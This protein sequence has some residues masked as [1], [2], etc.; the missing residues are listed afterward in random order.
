MKPLICVPMGDP[1]GIGPE[2]VI[3]SVSHAR[4]NDKSRIL[5]TGNLE[6]LERAAGVCE[7]SV[8]INTIEAISDLVDQPNVLNLFPVVCPPQSS[9]VFG[10]VSDIAGITAY[11][12]IEAAVR[13]AL[14]GVVDAIATTPIN[15]KSLRAA[16][17]E[18]I[19]HTEIL[20][21]LTNCPD[22]LTLFQVHGL[23][24]FFLSR[25]LS[26]RQACDFI[27]SQRIY[28]CAVRAV[29]ALRQL[30]VSEPRLAIAA[31]N[32]HAGEDGLF[33]DEE[34]YEIHPAV[35]QL[36][37]D[38]FSVAG[39]LPADS[40]FHQALLGQYDAVVSL[41]HDQGHIATKMID[42][43]KTISITCGLPFLRTSVDH[44]T[45]FDIA[46]KGFANPVS[47]IE[48]IQLAAKYAVPVKTLL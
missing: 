14:D 32:P 38:G 48:A 43:E 9:V 15:K 30:G 31:L 29:S 45:A 41:Y 16:G 10:Q 20:A 2:L 39:P 34:I 1:A 26:L 19:G 18:H 21:E 3:R 37:K 44:G 25:H 28:D 24:V 8:T 36:R 47:M 12:C 6:A 27:T 23:R 13:L 5:V 17:I 22:P 7:T 4:L 11:R 46:G 42:F 40:V 35:E 33:G